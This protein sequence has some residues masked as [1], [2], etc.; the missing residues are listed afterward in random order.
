M[1]LL[2]AAS[3]GCVEAEFADSFHGWCRLCVVVFGV[4]IE[5]LVTVV[6]AFRSD[7][8]GVGG[9]PAVADFDVDRWWG[10]A[11]VALTKTNPCR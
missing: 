8:W 10:L 9:A 11:E 5:E 4:E 7:W 3:D 2:I 6:G 1:L